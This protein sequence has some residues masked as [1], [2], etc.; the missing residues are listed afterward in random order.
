MSLKDTKCP[1]YLDVPAS[2]ESKASHQS[3]V[4]QHFKGAVCSVI[5]M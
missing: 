4:C 5:M 2:E 1:N 3:I